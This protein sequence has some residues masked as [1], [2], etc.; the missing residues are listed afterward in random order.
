MADEKTS[1]SFH[2]LA[3]ADP[4]DRVAFLSPGVLAVLRAA[5]PE[6]LRYSGDSLGAQLRRRRR[7]LG[8]RQCDAARTM[9]ADPK[10]V[11]W[12]ERD[13]RPPLVHMYPAI[14]AFLGYEPWPEPET[15]GEAL[16]AERRRRGLA[17]KQAAPLVGVDE[18]T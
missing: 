7:E 1:E 14:I 2:F 11:W 8:I 3:S 5:K 4:H 9:G 12:W 17:V 6:V 18:G 15:L 10:S 13:G 16:R